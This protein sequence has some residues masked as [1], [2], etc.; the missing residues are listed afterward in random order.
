MAGLFRG[1]LEVTAVH[2]H[3]NEISPH[4]MYMHYEGHGEAVTVAT[5]LRQALSS[6]GTPVRGTATAAAAPAAGQLD[7]KQVDQA[8]GRTGR[9]LHRGLPGERSPDGS[10]HGD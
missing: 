5:A 4:V 8:L 6:R 3:L 10:G 1:G 9:D 7:T 2:N